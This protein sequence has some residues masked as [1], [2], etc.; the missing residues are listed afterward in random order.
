MPSNNN[1]NGHVSLSL[2]ESSSGSSV[3]DR[4]TND[5]PSHQPQQEDNNAFPDTVDFGTTCNASTDSVSPLR[6]HHTH[7]AIMRFDHTDAYNMT[8][9]IPPACPQQPMIDNR[10]LPYIPIRL[11]ASGVSVY[12]SPEVLSTCPM[13]LQSLQADVTQA[14]RVLPP[15]VHALVRRTN[16]WVNASYSYGLSSD[17]QVLRHLTTHHQEGWLVECA[18]DSPLK[19]GG[20]EVYSCWDFQAMRLHW[21]GSGLLLHELCH[22][23]HQ[24]C[25]E[26]GL[27][28]LAVEQLYRQA[29]ESGKYENVLRRDWAGL[30]EDYDLAYA[31]VDKKEFFAE[32]SVAFLCHGYQHL[33]RKD[34][35]VMEECCP[36]LLHP[37]VTERVM[38]LHGIQDHPL[39][40]DDENRIQSCWWSLFRG[41]RRPQPKVRMVDPIFAEAA[42]SRCCANIDHCNKFYP[43][44]RGQLQHYDPELFRGIRDVWRGISMWDDPKNLKSQSCFGFT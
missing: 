17:P 19:A 41:I 10:Q 11:P 12:C 29:R 35:N 39:E 21:N 1:R 43:F 2:R 32:M 40:D 26:D 34:C 4:D 7:D 27:D 38:K 31:M 6:N 3:D 37:V 42:I 22:L 30:T 44:T 9:S 33:N 16:L 25:L 36:P 28:N 18:R 13:V 24:Y 23:I 8:I 14:L 5:K 20:I 15:S